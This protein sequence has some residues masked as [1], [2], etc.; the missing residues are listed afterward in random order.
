MVELLMPNNLYDLPLEY[1]TI[2]PNNHA[3][4]FGLGGEVRIE[5]GGDRLDHWDILDGMVGHHIL[6]NWPFRRHSG[7]LFDTASSDRLAFLQS[8]FYYGTL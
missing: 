7:S 5:Q 6:Q 1:N 2:R 3:D 8:V 4:R